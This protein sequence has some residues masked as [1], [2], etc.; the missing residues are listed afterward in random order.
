MIIY[1][2]P[3]CSTS[4]NALKLLKE[5]GC[6]VQ[7]RNYLEQP[8]TQKELRELLKMLGLKAIDV[9]RKKEPLYQQKYRDR[10]VS[11][12]E[13]LKILSS[14]PILIERPIV[15]MDGKAV[16]GRPVEKVLDLVK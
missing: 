3:R 14:D 13:W 2:N 10:E 8:P 5:K 15:I 12:A 6:D 9:V 11:E 16:L 1:H 4:R 7:I